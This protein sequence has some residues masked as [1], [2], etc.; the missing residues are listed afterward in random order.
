VARD[1]AD[2]SA[3]RGLRIRRP[4]AVFGFHVELREW[5]P[6]RVR[7]SVG[8]RE[9]LQIDQAVH[10]RDDIEEFRAAVLLLRVRV[11]ALLDLAGSRFAGTGRVDWR[12]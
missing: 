1:D 9:W 5:S 8:N 6:H 12:V 10:G 3:E 11:S 7:L 2:L 4:S